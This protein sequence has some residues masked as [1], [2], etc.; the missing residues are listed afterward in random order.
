MNVLIVEAH[1]DLAALWQRHLVRGGAEVR[2]ATTAD[3]AIG[4]LMNWNVD[5]IVLDIQPGAGSAIAI[6][7]Y[8]SYRRPG[9]RVIFVTRSRFF[10]DG[11]IFNLVP[12]AAAYLEAHTAPEDLAAIVEHHAIM[13]ASEQAPAHAAGSNQ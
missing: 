3:E 8:A 6:A 9:A 13:R 10:S 1:P 5:V 12:N 4:V 11:S 2:M 7:D